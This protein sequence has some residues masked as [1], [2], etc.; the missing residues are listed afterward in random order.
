MRLQPILFTLASIALVSSLLAGYFFYSNVKSDLSHEANQEAVNKVAETTS[1]FSFFLGEQL[2]PVRT[3]AG[4]SEIRRVFVKRTLETTKDANAILDLFATTLGANVCYLMDDKGMTIASSN[5]REPDSFVGLSF[6]FRPYFQRAIRGTSAIYMA[7]GTAS[8]IRGVYYSYPVLDPL[9]RQPVGVAVI[10]ASIAESE[11]EFT[12]FITG[13]E[14]LL[15]KDPHGIIFASSRKDW[16]F[17]SLWRLSPGDT[18]RLGVSQQ[19][20]DGPWEWLGYTRSS[21]N[22][23]VLGPDNQEMGFYE[24]PIEAFPE[25]SIVYLRP[26]PSV[27]ATIL[28]PIQHLPGIL[29]TIFSLSLVTIVVYLYWRALSEIT[30]R[31]TVEAALLES[32]QRFRRFYFQTPAMLYSIDS[33]CRIVR[34]SDY[35]CTALGYSREEVLGRKI[36][37]FMTPD[38]QMASEEC[39][40]PKLLET[41]SCKDIAHQFYTKEGE[42]RDVLLSAVRER[43]AG[44]E[45]A[46]S[47]CILVDIT[48]LKKAE[49]K[50]QEATEELRIHSRNLERQVRERTREISSILRHTTAVVYMKDTIGRYLLIN[51]RY[52]KLFDIGLDEIRGKT[53]KDVFDPV[54]AQQFQKNDREVLARSEP[55]QIEEKVPQADGIHTYISVKFPM[56]DEAGQIIGLGGISTDITEL[57]RAQEK[58]QQLSNRLLSSQENERTAIARELH[59]ELG[60]AL[61]ALKMDAAW[62]EKRLADRSD[63]MARRSAAMSELIDKTIDEVR[64][65]AVR[66][67]PVVLDDLGLLPA[68]EWLVHDFEKRMAIPCR[69]R[70]SNVPDLQ[71]GTASEVYRITQEALTNVARHAEAT[72]ADVSLTSNGTEIILRVKDDGRGFDTDSLRETEGLGLSGIRERAQLLDGTVKIESVLNEGAVIEVRFP[73]QKERA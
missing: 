24:Q 47:L 26:L 10:K 22:H 66:L 40:I 31:K 72:F 41:G 59:D 28:A 44:Q 39:L 8:G 73:L 67:R 17:R 68:L 35:W 43:Q 58:L 63:D 20:G 25:W 48:A 36:T 34:V 14:T 69:F 2:K 30:R 15:L 33:N 42:I 5:R 57:K 9:N 19:F 71:D 52:E 6:A 7:L 3:L 38:F 29:M 49:A 4:L 50:L 53:D 12:R 46:R 13:D 55:L 11:K 65:M 70:H 45:T 21:A 54:T 18:Q 32:E 16:L 51:S 60:Q 23:R 1:R 56:F 27:W 64:N 37:Q 62:L 61:T